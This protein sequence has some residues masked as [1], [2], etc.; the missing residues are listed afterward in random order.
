LTPST[1]SRKW[2]KTRPL[3]LNEFSRPAVACGPRSRNSHAV[4]E[5]VE[6]ASIVAGARTLARFIVG[7]FSSDAHRSA[8][9]ALLQSQGAQP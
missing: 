8:R 2:F 9:R 1:C 7:F 3:D 6:L 5:A 4:D